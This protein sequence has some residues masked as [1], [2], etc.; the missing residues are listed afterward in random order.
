MAI[1]N[2]IERIERATDRNRSGMPAAAL[3]A[4]TT[5]P[6]HTPTPSP[7]SR[8]RNDF[9]SVVMD[10]LPCAHCSKSFPSKS[11]LNKHHKVVHLKLKPHVCPEHGC[12]STFPH[13]Y[14]L[15]GHRNAVHLKLKPHR[16]AICQKS[17]GEKSNRNKRLRNVH[18]RHPGGP[19]PKNVV[20]S[21]L[22]KFSW[23]EMDA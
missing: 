16:C 5:S 14:Q 20:A 9:W 21:H 11:A 13:R 17:F 8:N 7:K 19:I 4:T 22:H 23:N 12:H 3:T 10:R 15:Q 6:P 1:T 2:R 18:N